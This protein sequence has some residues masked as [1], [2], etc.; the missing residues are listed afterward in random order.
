MILFRDEYTL[1]ILLRTSG[2]CPQFH[3]LNLLTVIWNV[4]YCRSW[5]ALQHYVSLLQ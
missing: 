4:F 5:P 2:I 1:S 3:Q